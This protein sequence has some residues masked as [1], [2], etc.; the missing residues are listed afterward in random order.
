M[1]IIY[2]HQ[3]FKFPH[4]SGGTRSYDLAKGFINLGHK[5]EMITSTSDLKYFS[6]DRWCK[7]EKNELIIHY[8]YLHYD[9]NLNF[10]QRIIVFLKFLWFS[11]FKLFSLKGD[12]IISSSTPLTIGIPSLLNK[13]I[14]KTPFIFETRDLWPEAAI[15]IGAIK[16]KLLKKILY[17]IESLIYKNANA[18][19]PL[20]RD[21][22][23]K[24]VTKYPNL[25]KIPIEVIE[26]ISDLNRFQNRYN[27]K[28]SLIE[29]KIGYKPRFTIL[30]A[31]TFGLVNGIDYVINFAKKL[32]DMDPS[33]IFILIGEGSQK[34]KIIKKS[35]DEKVINKNVFFL[36]SI[37]KDELPQLYYESD[38]GSSFVIP[39]KELWA[40]SANKF[41]DTLAA[42]RPILINH[43]GWQEKVIN[44]KDI[45]YV[46]PTTL[47]KNDIKEFINYSY[48]KELIKKQRAKAIKTA[49]ENYA[50]HIAISKYN[51]IFKNILNVSK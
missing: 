21:M 28:I 37:S 19:V 2:L 11:S 6:K 45:G 25:K 1:K 4:E 38:M 48:N 34:K 7:F 26:N 32:I 3:Y 18:I 49:R 29:E 50:T 44:K 17:S 31:G 10:Y 15:A 41:F 42:G 51:N 22:R 39:V 35:I 20:S 5:V 46:L 8:L 23:E 30:Y 47:S 40:N 13:W 16:N 33:I 36:D 43:K 12:I 24:I 27:K 14:Y 9:N